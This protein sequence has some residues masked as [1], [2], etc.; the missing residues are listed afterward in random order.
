[1]TTHTLLSRV[2]SPAD[3]KDL[4]PDELSRLSGEIRD[5]IVHTVSNN[6]GHLASSLGAVELAIALHRAFNSPRDKI[7][8]DVGHQSYPHKLLTGRKERFTTLRL[9][10]GLSGFPDPFESSHD[11]F[12]GGHAGNSI[13]AA[14][15]MALAGSLGADDFTT[16]AVIGDGSIGAGM[17]YEA[18]NHAGHMNIKLII[19]LNDNGMSISPSVGS[20]SR[21]LMRIRESHILSA[22]N[23]GNDDLDR[24]ESILDTLGFHYIGP[25]DGHNIQEMEAAFLET[26][27]SM[28]RPAVIHVITK[29]G[30]GYEPAEKDSVTFHGISP[31]RKKIA[32]PTYSAVFS[33]T[34]LRLMETNDRI[35]AITAAMKEGTGL[36]E[37]AARF[38]DRVFD[39][40]ISEQHAVTM[41]GG[42]ATLGFIPVVAI[43]SSFLQRSYDQIVNDVCL[44]RLPVVFAIDRA[45]IVGD[46]GKTHHGAFD[47]SYLRSI[48]DMVVSAPKDERELQDLLV[49]AVCADRPMAIRYPRGNGEGIPLH[50]EPA[51]IPIGR[52]EVLRK[53]QDLAI[54]AFGTMV[55]QAMIAADML[56]VAG[57]DCAVVNARFA[58]P[59]DEELI[60]DLACK[61]GR[62]LTIEENA[63]NGGFGSAVAELLAAK[64]VMARLECLGIPDRFIT[65]GTQE[66]LRAGLDLDANGIVRRVRQSFPELVLDE[67][68]QKMEKII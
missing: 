40:G 5:A 58:K 20:L 10:N 29:K 6:G 57:I 45:G 32:A 61:I 19:I 18:M 34:M 13:S 21:L 28:T 9:H 47:V 2:D 12:S 56:D 52:G 53:G 33:R 14:M 24:A 39:T 15:G 41:A 36:A 66:L 4:T 17:A 44:L 23:G 67:I 65:H 27:K 68:D 1:M 25:L 50:G 49:T 63:L 31:K 26:K 48:P 3:I 60:V 22:A 54:I 35:V 46:D 37:A 38:P 11:P 8:W 51:E 7:I 30:K 43:Y 16:V 59:L 42:L 62:M 64:G 55:N